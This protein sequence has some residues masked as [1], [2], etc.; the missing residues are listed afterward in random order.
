MQRAAVLALVDA[1][2]SATSGAVPLRAGLAEM[3]AAVAALGAGAGG[4]TRRALQ[5]L[6]VDLMVLSGAVGSRTAELDG[7][8]GFGG[9]S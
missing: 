6:T 8:A 4:S 5:V 7:L 2:D 9:V 1:V 3:V